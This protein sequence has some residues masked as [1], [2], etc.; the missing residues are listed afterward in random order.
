VRSLVHAFKYGGRR[1]VL[2]PLGRR[3]AESARLGSL[4][5]AERDA[6]VV[7]VPGRAGAV[8][9]RGYDQAEDLARGFARALG[10]PHAERALRRRRQ[11]EDAQAGRSVRRRRRMVRASFRADAGLLAG[12]P[13]LLV[14]DVLST[15]ATADAAARALRLAGVP[16]VTVFTLAT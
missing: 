15:G 11:P 6:L 2:L 12:R 16:R 14:D 5:R 3:R 10:R 8:R 4:A 13:V 1:D 9:R 7:H